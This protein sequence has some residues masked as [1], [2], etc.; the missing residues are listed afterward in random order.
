MKL[1]Y[2]GI[3]S[4]LSPRER[5]LLEAKVNN[6]FA[7]LSKIVER[8]GERDAR[9]VLT[10]ERHLFHAELTMNLWDHALVATGSNRD[11]FEAINQAISKLEKQAMKLRTK[12]RDTKRAPKAKGVAEAPARALAA[13]GRR[14]GAAAMDQAEGPRVFRVNHYERRKPITLD[15]AMLEIGKKNDYL[16]F[17][18]ADRE[19]ISVLIRRKDGH[20]DLIEA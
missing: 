6:R 14:T 11:P 3:R 10:H 16:V 8:R 2:S 18:D 15:E 12:W 1:T 17:R 5:D 4:E 7:M 9:I 19:S 20:F 13:T